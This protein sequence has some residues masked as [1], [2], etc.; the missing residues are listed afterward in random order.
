VGSREVEQRREVHRR[1]YQARVASGA[2]AAYRPRHAK[3]QRAWRARNRDK[4][5][6]RNKIYREANRE[7]LRTRMREWSAKHRDSLKVRNSEWRAVNLP[8][9]LWHAAKRRAV[10]CSIPFTIK[11]TDI[12][13]PKR[14]PVFG[15]KLVRPMGRGRGKI[16][17]D[18]PTLDRINPAKG[19][20]A[21]NIAVISHRAN[22]LK[23]NA[24]AKEHRRIAE[25]MESNARG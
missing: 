2:W 24:T 22:R 16:T 7:K 9:V 21:S 1:K 10:Q 20:V 19:Y 15:K 8:I 17:P 14:C 4:L 11:P 13:I 3:N 12:I 5:K 23:S 18:S 25:W 6:A